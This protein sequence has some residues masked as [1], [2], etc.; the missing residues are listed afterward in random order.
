MTWIMLKWDHLRLREGD[1][2][3][4]WKSG[5]HSLFFSAWRISTGVAFLSHFFALVCL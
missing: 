4:S 5:F 3:I 2:N 1:I